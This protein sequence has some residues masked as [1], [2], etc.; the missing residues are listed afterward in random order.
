MKRTLSYLL[1]VALCISLLTTSTACFFKH[2][3]DRFKEQL[4][5]VDS[6]QMTITMTNIPLFGTV[7]MTTQI[8]GNIQYNSGT[9]FSDEEYIEIYETVQ[10]K[11]TKGVNGKWSK[12]IYTDF[13]DDKLIDDEMME[14]LFNPQNY[15][16]VRGEK[17]TYKQKADVNF[18]NCKDVTITI[19][20]EQCSIEMQTTSQG[21]VV[22]LELVISKLGE[23]ELTL[24][25]VS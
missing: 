24:P 19:T 5:T 1:I 14:Q 9:F 11:Y 4:E 6:C 7:A 20:Q 12:S 8:D 10:Y 16:K 13:N 25:N 3:I 21:M 17:Y 22:D 18:D 2:P 15:E 23:V